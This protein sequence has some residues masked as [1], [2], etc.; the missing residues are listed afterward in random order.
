MYNQTNG[1]I[2]HNQTNVKLDIQ[3]GRGK[4]TEQNKNKTKRDNRNEKTNTLEDKVQK[5]KNDN[6]LRKDLR[7]LVRKDLKS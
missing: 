6:D 4:Q 2:E 1:E 7:K 3:I 5:M